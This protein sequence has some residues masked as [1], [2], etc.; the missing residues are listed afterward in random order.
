MFLP[1]IDGFLPLPRTM[2]G[3]TAEPSSLRAVEE[4]DRWCKYFCRS[5]A[6]FLIIRRTIKRPWTLVTSLGPALR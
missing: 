1:R 2:R 4:D 6:Y 5:C 3:R